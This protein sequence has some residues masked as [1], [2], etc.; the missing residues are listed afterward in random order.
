M[1]PNTAAILN[2]IQNRIVKTAESYPYPS[3]RG[4]IIRLVAIRFAF[5]LVR[6]FL[7]TSQ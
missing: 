6:T 3:E 7:C 5:N 2:H 4:L 1:N